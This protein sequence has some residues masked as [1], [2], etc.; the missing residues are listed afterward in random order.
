ME[1]SYFPTDKE[2]VYYAELDDADL[3]Q[4]QVNYA[5]VILSIMGVCKHLR[6][7]LALQASTGTILRILGHTVAGSCSTQ[8]N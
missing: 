5:G 8:A 4:G 1:Y 6:I 2:T 3:E 7:M